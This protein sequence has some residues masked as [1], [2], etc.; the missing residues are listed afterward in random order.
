MVLPR[1]KYEEYVQGVKSSSS[2]LF[3]DWLQEIPHV[4]VDQGWPVILHP[5]AAVRDVSA[6]S[7]GRDNSLWVNQWPINHPGHLYVQPWQQGMPRPFRTPHWISPAATNMCLG[8][9]QLT[10]FVCCQPQ[11]CVCQPLS[12]P[13]P[14]HYHPG[15]TRNHYILTSSIHYCCPNNKHVIKENHNKW[16]LSISTQES[17]REHR[18][19][20]QWL[21]EA[22][23]TTSNKKQKQNLM[24]LHPT[25]PKLGHE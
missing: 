24:S 15:N 1:V 14:Y 25:F 18:C 8:C 16:N 9:N 19:T 3:L 11:W 12:C 13:V 22:N 23:Q 2:V 10:L 20:S 6:H 7:K 5:V 4:L 17:W 21:E